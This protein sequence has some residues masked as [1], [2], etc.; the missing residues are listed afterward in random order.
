MS[1]NVISRKDYRATSENK[2]QENNNFFKELKSLLNKKTTNKPHSMCYHL[3]KYFVENKNQSLSSQELLFHLINIFEK[4]PETLLTNSEEEFKNIK[5]LKTSFTKLINKNIIFE[6]DPKE[7]K[8]KLNELNALY[9]IKTQ[10]ETI[11]DKTPYKMSSRSQKLGSNETKK[12]VKSPPKTS[13]SRKIKKE[14]EEEDVKLKIKKEEVRIKEEEKEKKDSAEKVKIKEEEVKIKEEE[15]IKEEKI[16]DDELMFDSLIELFNGKFYDEFYLSFSEQGLY[17]QLQEKIEK[18]QEKLSPNNI[19]GGSDGSGG[20]DCVN[21]NE[22]PE[23]LDKIKN[24]KLSLDELNKNKEEYD[25][26]INEFDQKKKNLNAYIELLRLKNKEIK[27]AKE[28]LNKDNPNVRDLAKEAKE[29]CIFDKK[30]HDLVYEQLTDSY[31]KIINLIQDSKKVK[32]SIKK[33]YINIIEK[34]AS[35]FE[36]ASEFYEIVDNLKNE[37]SPS[38]EKIIKCEHI[39]QKYDQFSKEFDK[40]MNDLIP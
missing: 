12:G 25:K 16:D 2:S 37:N 29:V 27:I 9:Y 38:L 31:K 39:F 1:K 3:I 36:D 17:E 8:Y 7:D 19:S 15:K 30:N 34:N 11:N 10:T 26:L 6:E 21:N 33:S 23:Y 40:K 24:I 20:S 32:D 18:L 35:K 13:N 22:Q 14:K 5:G 28:L 4:Y